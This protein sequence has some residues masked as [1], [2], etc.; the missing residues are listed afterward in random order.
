[1]Y[2]IFVVICQWASIECLHHELLMNIINFFLPLIIC[3]GIQVSG[4]DIFTV[5]LVSCQNLKSV[6]VEIVELWNA[7]RLLL[8]RAS[9]YSLVYKAVNH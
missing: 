7:Q 1:M 9:A 6:A 3:S 2:A 4:I 5:I 8:P